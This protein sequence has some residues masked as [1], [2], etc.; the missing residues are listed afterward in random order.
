MTRK[1]F[2]KQV[3]TI[4]RKRRTALLR[5]VNDELQDMQTAEPFDVR[6]PIDAAVDDEFRSLATNLA[7]LESRELERIEHAMQR[8]DD[9]TYGIC[10][11]CQ[12]TIPLARLRVIP[13]ASTCVKCA[14][15][16]ETHDNSNH[17]HQ[18]WSHVTDFADD[19]VEPPTVWLAEFT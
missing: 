5:S 10:E 6:D 8:L 14:S 4:L 16:K 9:G 2:M 17:F 3:E 1:E 18:R 19:D 13:H 15:S 11:Q 7:E 12:R